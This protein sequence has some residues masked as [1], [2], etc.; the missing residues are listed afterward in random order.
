MHTFLSSNG[1]VFHHNGDFSGPTYIFVPE[2]K[3]EFVIST[4][5]LVEFA[6]HFIDDQFDAAFDYIED[7]IYDPIKKEEI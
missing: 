5:A 4:K 3:K 2:Y 6:Q 7:D 1:Y